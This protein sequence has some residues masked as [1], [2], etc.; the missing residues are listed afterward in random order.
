M[1]SKMKGLVFPIV[2]GLYATSLFCQPKMQ[3]S[4]TEH[5]FGVFKEESGRQTFNFIVTNSGNTPL[6]IQNVVPSC[7]YTTLDWIKEPI[8]VEGLGTV[9]AS[10][11]PLNRPGPINKSLTV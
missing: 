4:T 11:D 10:Y 9:T 3:L 5:D 1:L 6:V 7:G 8:A 2:M